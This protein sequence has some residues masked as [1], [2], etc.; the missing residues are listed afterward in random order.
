MKTRPGGESVDGAEGTSGAKARRGAGIVR[1][2][3]IGLLVL[4]VLT[5]LGLL[6]PHWFRAGAAW[7]EWGPEEIKKMLGYVPA[8]LG[9]LTGL[10]RAP[11][12]DYAPPGAESAGM[13]HQGAMY[14]VSALLGLAIVGGLSF[15]LARWLS[16]N[17]PDE[18][19][20]SDESD[21]RA[22]GVAH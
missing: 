5:P 22:S 15:L 17:E 10:W 3:W 20:Q 18:P 2:L 21:E 8:Q 1:R 19:D 12:P 13:G 7:G 11:M 14:I 16:R 9:R 6:V 4:A